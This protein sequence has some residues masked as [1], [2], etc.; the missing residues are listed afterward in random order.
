MAE[1]TIEQELKAIKTIAEAL[2]PL[3]VEARRRALSYAMQHLNLSA[4]FTPSVRPTEQPAQV[5]A[6]ANRSVAAGQSFAQSGRVVDIR[7]LKEQKK[8]TSD[9]EM[10]TLVAYY[11]RHEAP[12]DE[13]KA[14]V[15]AEDLEKY[16][17]QAGYPLPA[18]KKYTLQN[19]KKAGYVENASRGKYKL[20]SVGHNLIVHGLPRSETTALSKP[21]RRKVP[22]KKAVTKKAV[23]K[24]A[25][26]KAKR[27]SKG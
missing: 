13:Q 22:T 19:A 2:Q 5:E 3:D 8:P 14:E 10:A 23:T 21:K 17:V 7:S 18:E 1:T 27:K 6:L 24:K 15:G 11:L 12:E 9:I 4:P 25:G 16:F 20:N 26:K